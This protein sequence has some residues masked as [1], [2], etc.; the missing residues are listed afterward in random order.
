VSSGGGA[1][2]GGRRRLLLLETSWL[3]VQTLAARLGVGLDAAPAAGAAGLLRYR[4]PA[5]FWDRQQGQLASRHRDAARQRLDHWLSDLGEPLLCLAPSPHEILPLSET[6]RPLLGG[7]Q[8]RRAL[9]LSPLAECSPDRL[10]AAFGP[11]ARCVPGWDLRRLGAAFTELEQ[12]GPWPPLAG[13]DGG[14]PLG[15]PPASWPDPLPRLQLDLAALPRGAALAAWLERRRSFLLADDGLS[16]A[17]EL[18]GGG[19]L[20]LRVACR[21]FGFDAADLAALRETRCRSIGS[22]AAPGWSLHLELEVPP[23][24][25]AFDPRALREAGFASLS[26][27]LP[28]GASLLEACRGAGLSVGRRALPKPGP[29]AA[30]ARLSEAL[31]MAA[32]PSGPA[33]GDDAAA[34][35]ARGAGQAPVAARRMAR[36]W[37]AEA[38]GEPAAA[39]AQALRAARAATMSGR[40]AVELGRLLLLAGADPQQLEPLED[41]AGLFLDFGRLVQELALSEAAQGRPEVGVRHLRAWLRGWLP[42]ALDDP[43]PPPSAAVQPLSTLA[44]LQARAGQTV[45]AAQTRARLWAHPQGPR[46]AGPEEFWRS[47]SAAEWA[48][49]SPA[50]LRRPPPAPGGAARLRPRGARGPQLELVSLLRDEEGQRRVLPS[51]C[52]SLVGALRRAGRS[53]RLHDRQLVSPA[54]FAD[55]LDLVASLGEP[56]PVIGISAMADRLPLVVRCVAAL[57]EAFP[58]R[59]LIAGGA[60]PSTQPGALLALAT[61]LDAVVRG[62]GEETLV[63]LLQRLDAGGVAELEGCAGV[64]FRHPDGSILHGPPRPRIQDLDAL[65]PPAYDAVDP[66]LYDELT[67]VTSRGCPHGCSFCDAACLWGNRRVER[68][69]ESVFDEIEDLAARHGLQHLHVED[70]SFLDRGARVQQFCQL[71]QRRVPGLTWGCLGRADRAQEPLLQQM[72]AAGCRSLFLGLESGSERVLRCVGKGFGP[73]T[74]LAAAGAALRLLSVRAYFIWGFPCETWEDFEATFEAVGVL[75]YLGAEACYSLLAP[76]P[77]TPLMR[78]WG[79]P[80][81]FEPHLPFPCL[82]HPSDGPEDLALVQAHPEAFPFFHVLRTPEWERKRDFV[83]AYWRADLRHPRLR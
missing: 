46:V 76:F 31:A 37:L 65:A 68:S 69:L 51:G 29:P 5:L 42:D 39:L 75:R 71:V 52:L 50:T 81:H 45:D 58:D 14:Q 54:R 9:V 48:A 77:D 64:S 17:P 19:S 47:D 40:A 34:V 24:A 43:G 61:G 16:S 4:D 62:E 3:A 8:G 80:L 83:T 25:S 60:G 2:A 44:W 22:A 1:P 56:G 10:A 26:A 79:G 28:L 15:L 18:D 38:R 21:S 33:P 23:E 32:A 66:A 6:L 82:F 27:R 55:P 20:V 12:P 41:E 73:A 13:Q 7:P 35:A 49:L 57:R 78:R 67:L 36:A 59:V 11:L 74:G 53:A 30:A 72:V 63:E 70:D